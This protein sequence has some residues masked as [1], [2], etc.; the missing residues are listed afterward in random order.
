MVAE[1]GR[2]PHAA[3]ERPPSPDWD[4]LGSHTDRIIL[5]WERIVDAAIQIKLLRALWGTLGQYLQHVT[6]RGRL[7]DGDAGAGSRTRSSAP[8]RR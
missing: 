1:R 3:P 4:F 7:A 8:R 5:N 2:S 6:Q